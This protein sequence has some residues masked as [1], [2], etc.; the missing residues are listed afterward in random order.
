[1][2]RLAACVKPGPRHPPLRF[3]PEFPLRYS[4]M[5]RNTVGDGA[6]AQQNA[7]AARV[8]GPAGAVGSCGGAT[9]AVG[10]NAP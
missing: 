10:P 5:G 8:S 2:P 7:P 4:H 1:M 9:S 6:R 3:T